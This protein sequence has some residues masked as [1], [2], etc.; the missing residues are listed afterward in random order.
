MDNTESFKGIKEGLS[1]EEH[2]NIHHDSI[3]QPTNAYMTINREDNGIQG[4]LDQGSCDCY[5][6]IGL[7]GRI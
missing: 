1:T 7:W 2:G 6:G 5:S 3:I 4:I